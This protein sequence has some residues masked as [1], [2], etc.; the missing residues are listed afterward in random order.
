[1]LVSAIFV[2]KIIDVNDDNPMNMGNMDIYEKR[3]IRH[4]IVHAI[5]FESGLDHNADWPRNEEIIDWIA[6]Q[7]PKLLEIFKSLKV[8][9]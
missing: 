2:L 7:F 1:M 9:S 3:T 8:D 5:L 6:I 4:E